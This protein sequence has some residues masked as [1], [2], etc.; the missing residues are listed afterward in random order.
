M[1]NPNP[2]PKL[3]LAIPS[4]RN[5]PQVK[6]HIDEIKG[7]GIDIDIEKLWIK[8][9]SET[10]AYAVMED[11]F[12]NHSDADYLVICPDDLVVEQRHVDALVKTI[13]DNGGPDKMPVLSG[14]CN[15]DMTAG[16]SMKLC[17]SVDMVVHPQRRRRHWIWMDMRSKEWR[18]DYSRRPI[19]PVKFSGFACQFIR[20]D[21]V[22]SIGLHGDLQYNELHR[23]AQDYSF[24]VIFCWL[25]NKNSIPM[26]VN[27]SIRMLHLRGGDSRKVQGIEPLLVGRPGYDKKVLFVNAEGKEEDVTSKVK[28]KVKVEPEPESQVVAT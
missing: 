9:H 14:V 22:Q 23:Q 8:Y 7:S 12:L 18:E 1:T 17:I 10:D 20:R 26:Y 16:Q 19:F 15:F 21:I 27:P 11:W 5:I 6:K 4:P 2:S 3:L 13:Q 28:V 25:C 24:D